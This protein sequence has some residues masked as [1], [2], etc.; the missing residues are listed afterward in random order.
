M[1]EPHLTK[2]QIRRLLKFR[3]YGNPAGRYWFIG[4]EEGG[5][6]PWEELAGRADKWGEIEDLA[7]VCRPWAPNLDLTKCITPTWWIMCRVIGRLS[8][9]PWRDTDFVREYQS[10]RL[11]RRDGETFLTELLPLPKKNI[12]DWPFGFLYPTRQDYEDAVRPDR[13]EGL[14]EL[15]ADHKPKY[16]FCYGKANWKHYKSVFRDAE[17]TPIL[18]GAAQIA[19]VGKSTIALTAFLDPTIVGKVEVFVEQLGHEVEAAR[20]SG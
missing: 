5:S 10:T 12:G 17:F 16:V 6:N 19:T 14:R 18:D 4:M 3:G 7:R 15:F 13:I 1:P 9:K 8:G 20:A 2:E 11:G